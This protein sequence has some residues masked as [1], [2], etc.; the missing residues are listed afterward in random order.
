MKIVWFVT[1]IEMK[2]KV[3]ALASIA[4]ASD[5]NSSEWNNNFLKIFK[6]INNSHFRD[7]LYAN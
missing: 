7:I 3:S 4:H 2:M 6:F 5:K 1:Q